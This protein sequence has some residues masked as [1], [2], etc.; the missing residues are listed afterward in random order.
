VAETLR[1]RAVFAIAVAVFTLS[2]CM[3]A[4]G[5]S[6]MMVAARVPG[7]RRGVMMEVR[8]AGDPCARSRSRMLR[9]AIELRIISGLIGPLLAR[10]SAV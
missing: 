6:P 5:Q 1:Q 3:R 7:R 10:R 2:R 9:R 8:P 4:G